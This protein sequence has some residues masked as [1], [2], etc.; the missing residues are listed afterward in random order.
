[1]AIQFWPFEIALIPPVFEHEKLRLQ[2]I[3][4]SWTMTTD[5]TPLGDQQT[6]AAQIQNNKM[7]QR[8]RSQERVEDHHSHIVDEDPLLISQ[9]LTYVT[10][11]GSVLH[12]FRAAHFS[13]G[14]SFNLVSTVAVFS[15]HSK[16]LTVK[17]LLR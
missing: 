11:D 9:S 4:C 12:S 7:L 5:S 17:L 10:D 14:K 6:T 15:C 16:F 1:M 13:M 2:L 3:Q 8:Q